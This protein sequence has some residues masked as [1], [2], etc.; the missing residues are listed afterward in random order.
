MRVPV[1]AGA[2]PKSTLVNSEVA[3]VKSST[4]A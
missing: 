3:S 4:G 1:S 2:S